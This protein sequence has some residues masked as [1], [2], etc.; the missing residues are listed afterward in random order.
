[1]VGDEEIKE[2][3]VLSKPSKSQTF[4]QDHRDLAP[5]SLVWILTLKISIVAFDLEEEKK[6]A[7][8]VL[9]FGD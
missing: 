1:M 5:G 9:C 6:R 7:G 3:H 4:S 8:C 2:I